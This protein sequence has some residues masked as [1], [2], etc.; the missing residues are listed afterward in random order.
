MPYQVD[1]ALLHAMSG[2]E[3]S[4]VRTELRLLLLSLTTKDCSRREEPTLLC[5]QVL[6]DR[7]HGLTADRCDACIFSGA[8]LELHIQRVRQKWMDQDH[9]T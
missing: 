2:T 8:L 3:L 6:F 4:R 1:D 9:H 7:F 5:N